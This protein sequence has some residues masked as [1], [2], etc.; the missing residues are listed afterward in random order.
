MVG[1]T[2]HGR[3]GRYDYYTCLRRHRH[4]KQKGCR[5]ELIPADQLEQQL[6]AVLASSLAD[7]GLLDKA[8]ARAS[9][10]AAGRQ[11]A[12]HAGSSLANRWI[13]TP[14]AVNGGARSLSWVCSGAARCDNAARTRAGSSRVSTRTR[15]P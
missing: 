11:P 6:L 3:N 5:C 1:W 14:L 9:E 2:A 8:L 13:Q 12:L 15:A 7:T 4:G 10:L